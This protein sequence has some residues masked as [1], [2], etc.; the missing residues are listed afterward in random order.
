MGDSTE[1]VGAATADIRS[2]ADIWIAVVEV[3]GRACA[4]L[5][6]VS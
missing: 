1:A 5:A 4:D 6:S 2:A 3:A